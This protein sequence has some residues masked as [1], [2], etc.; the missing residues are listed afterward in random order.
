MLENKFYK[1]GQSGSS[2][3][4]ATLFNPITKEEKRV[5]VYDGDYYDQ[6]YAGCDIEAYH[7][8]F[9]K[10]ARI[11]YLH[12]NGYAF[13]GDFVKIVS[14]RKML[15]EI[16]KIVR[17]WVYTQPCSYGRDWGKTYYFVFEDGTK[18]QQKHCKYY[19]SNKPTDELV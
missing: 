15:G 5:K 18:V 12:Y 19:E 3:V 11:E 7:M 1:V 2:F 6:E 14:G 4:T 13:V 10:E 16:K 9:N 17:E 8:P